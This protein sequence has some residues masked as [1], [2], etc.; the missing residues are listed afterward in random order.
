MGEHRGDVDMGSRRAVDAGE[1]AEIA[2]KGRHADLQIG[3]D[4]GDDLGA[5]AYEI[6]VLV[7]NLD[8]FVFAIGDVDV[9]LR[10]ADKNVVGFVEIAGLRTEVAPFFDVFA[11]LGKLYDAGRVVRVGRMAVRNKD[12]A[13]RRDRDAGRPI[14]R[15][16][17]I[18]GDALLAE[19]LLPLRPSAPG[20]CR[21]T[22][23]VR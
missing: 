4:R 21:H 9:V 14:E 16:V 23:G 11:V 17:T 7:E 13:V 2:G 19:R 8:P 12:V 5:E 6:A 22:P 10:A 15:I 20:R 3:A 18:A 1:R